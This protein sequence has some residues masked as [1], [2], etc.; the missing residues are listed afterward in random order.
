MSQNPST[1]NLTL[2]WWKHL[3]GYHWFVFFVASAAWCLDCLDQQLF[4]LARDN[5]LKAL[6]PT[7]DQAKLSGMAM[8]VFVA[9]WATGGLIFGAV[10]DRIGRA[11]TLAITV[12]IYSVFTGLSSLAADSTHFMIYRALTGLGVGGVFGLAVALVADSLPDAARAKALG[13]LQALSAVGNV[14]AGLFAMA[15]SGMDPNVSWKYLFWIGAAPAFLCIFIMIRLKEPEKWVAAKA[16]SQTDKSKSMGSY[17]SLFGD[18]RW[19]KPALF[20]MLLCVSAVIGLW[21]IGFFS[22]KL[23]APAIAQA[24]AAQNLSPAEIQAGKQWWAAANL[25]VQNI[26]AFF[27]MIMFTK[28]ASRFGRKPVFVVAFL[29]AMASTVMFYQFFKT[30]TDIWMSF[31]MGFCQLS[32]FAGFAIYLPELFPTRLRST[33]TSFCYNVGRFIAASGPITLGVLASNLAKTAKA[34]LPAIPEEGARKAA[35]AAAE[36]AAFRNAGTWMSLIF[37]LGLVALMFLPETKDRPLPED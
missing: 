1:P 14:T 16:L 15:V 35:E 17:A 28:A 3:N 20:G 32:I 22:N 31:V 10:G 7:G 21:G 9:G 13:T 24:L 33:G 12:L 2:P 8:A 4:I 30:T 34:A 36:L 26:G 37:L 11:K 19:R 29:A 27:G 23:T 18:A 5:A 6:D 25:I